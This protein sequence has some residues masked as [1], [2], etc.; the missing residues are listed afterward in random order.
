MDGGISVASEPEAQITPMA[1]L[2]S[3]PS[4]IIC[5][6]ATSPSITISPPMIPVIA[7]STSAT[8]VVCTA[9]PP[10][11]FPPSTAIASNKSRAIPERSRMEPIRTNSGTATSG[12]F[13]SSP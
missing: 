12:Y 2:R 4:R 11:R 6:R 9:T 13:S 1:S 10:R 8:A 7:A 3:Y 5:G